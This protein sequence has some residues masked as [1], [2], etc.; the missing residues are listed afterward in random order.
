MKLSTK[1]KLR[2]GLFALAA[3]FFAASAGGVLE[4]AAAHGGVVHYITAA[5]AAVAAFAAG[6]AALR[7]NK[8]ATEWYRLWKVTRQVPRSPCAHDVMFH[9]DEEPSPRPLVGT[10][11]RSPLQELSEKKPSAQKPPNPERKPMWPTV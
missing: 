1:M 6:R 10:D 9:I 3:G 8:D 2:T 5:F 4:Y 11:W 7:V